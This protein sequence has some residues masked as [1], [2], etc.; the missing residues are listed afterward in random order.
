[1]TEDR[2]QKAESGNL[3]SAARHLASVLPPLLLEAERV[4]SAVRQ[5]VHGR[6]R[7]GAGESFWQF[8]RYATGDA[9]Q[10]IDWRQSA[11]SD[12]LFVRERE[13]EAAQTAY[14]WADASGSMRYASRKDIPQK[15]ERARVLMLALADLLLRGGEK[16]TWLAREPIAVAGKGGLERI[17]ARFDEQQDKN[18]P[19]ALP[20]ARHAHMI[21]CSDFLMESGDLRDLMRRHAALN[22]KGAL[23]HVL[24]PAERD[25]PFAGRIEMRGFENEAPLLLANAGVLREAYRARMEE[26]RARLRQ[27]AQSAGWFYIAHTTDTQPGQALLQIYEALAADRQ[28]L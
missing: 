13:W 7:A 22:L 21:L 2:Y 10:R 20:F 8:R 3:P 18:L 9:A 23:V 6:R 4:A 1:M 11:R 5:G 17:A 15:I 28:G 19:P 14:L 24:D 16:V 26:H 12:K 25:L 27:Y